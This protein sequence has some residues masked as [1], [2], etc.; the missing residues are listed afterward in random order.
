M[1]HGPEAI[2]WKAMSELAWFYLLGTYDR[3]IILISAV[4]LPSSDTLISF[5]LVLV[6][7]F[8]VSRMQYLPD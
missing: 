5:R 3:R 4:K 2:Y 1:D 8:N 7:G 6:P